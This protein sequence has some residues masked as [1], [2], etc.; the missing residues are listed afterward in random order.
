M[1]TIENYQG[2]VEKIYKIDHP[3]VIKWTSYFKEKADIDDIFHNFNQSNLDSVDH[4][5]IVGRFW[6]EFSK[7][8]P[9]VLCICAGKVNCNLIR[10][11]II[12]TAF[13]ELGERNHKAIHPELFKDSLRRIDALGIT[14]G[15][16]ASL[17]TLELDTLDLFSESEILGFLLGM[18]LPAEENIESVFSGLSYD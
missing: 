3:K 1:E 4:A 8:A 16:I 14:N 12:Q 18:E 15:P 11:Y 10:H 7:L 13:E 2:V 17:R 5:K 9:K 6:Y